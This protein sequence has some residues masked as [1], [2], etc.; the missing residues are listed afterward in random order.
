[1]DLESRNAMDQRKQVYDSIGKGGYVLQV[2]VRKT[3]I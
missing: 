2:L 3:G 1:M